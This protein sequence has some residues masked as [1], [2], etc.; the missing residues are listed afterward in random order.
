MSTAPCLHKDYDGKKCWSIV[1][2]NGYCEKH[3]PPKWENPYYDKPKN[4]ASLKRYVIARD[5]GV[6]YVCGKPGADEVDHVI[7]KSEGGTDTTNNL[8]AI[9]QQVPPH[10]HR[11]KTLKEAWKARMGNKPLPYGGKRLS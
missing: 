5:K 10:C 2:K 6:C 1:Y 4:W 7:P 3:Q 8:K 9:H 11:E